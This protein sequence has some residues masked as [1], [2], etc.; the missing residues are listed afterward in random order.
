MNQSSKVEQNLPSFA[1]A[2]AG[3]PPVDISQAEWYKASLASFKNK[4]NPFYST[5]GTWDASNFK[6]QMEY[7]NY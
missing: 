6:S 2:S 7:R 3:D 5:A 4:Q 1:D